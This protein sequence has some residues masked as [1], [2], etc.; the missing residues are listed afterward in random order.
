MNTRSKQA[1]SKIPRQAVASTPDAGSSELSE[2]SEPGSPYLP[3][4]ITPKKKPNTSTSIS[5]S[6]KMN[7]KA[8]DQGFCLI[9][10]EKDPPIA[11]Q[12]CHILRRRTEEAKVRILRLLFSRCSHTICGNFRWMNIS[13]C[14]IYLNSMLIR[15]R[16]SFIVSLF[17]H[18]SQQLLTVSKYGPTGTLH[19]MT[20]AGLSY[21]P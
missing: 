9:T 1:P 18:R 19:T 20:I 6:Q 13:L 16:I 10:R 17:L 21:P 5:T 11:I 2:P 8:I 12:A 4:P 7:L 3:K 15:Q 14:G